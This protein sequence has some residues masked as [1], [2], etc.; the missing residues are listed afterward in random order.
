MARS[1]L[2][3]GGA[4]GMGRAAAHLLARDGASVTVVDRAADAARDVTREITDAGGTALAA[5]ADVGNED[6]VKTAVAAAVDAFGGLDGVMTSAGVFHGDDLRPLGEVELD[7]F[8]FVLRVNLVGTFLAMKHALPHL[9]ERRGAVV[10]IAS[11][12]ALKGHGY[13]PGYT[14]SKGGVAALTRIAAVQYGPQGVRVNCICPGSVDTPMTMGAW[15]TPEAQRRIERSVP[16][17][18]VAQPEEIASVAAFL[19]SDAASDVTGQTIAVDGGA[20]IA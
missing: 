11:T 17:Q 8:L 12:A 16:L 13:G 20:T 10:T 4:S 18:R 5:P 15:S 7:D 6:E 2:V 3:T 1:I 14:A 19:L 9:V